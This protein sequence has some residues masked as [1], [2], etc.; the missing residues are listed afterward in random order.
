MQYFVYCSDQLSDFMK[1]LNADHWLHCADH[2]RSL[3]D[4]FDAHVATSDKEQVSQ[5]NNDDI[6]ADNEKLPL[7]TH[8]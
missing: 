4:I 1:I 8:P 6:T 7:E 5:A 3:I 2:I